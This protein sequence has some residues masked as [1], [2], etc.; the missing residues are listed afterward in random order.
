MNSAPKAFHLSSPAVMQTLLDEAQ[1]ELAQARATIE[2]QESRL[3]VLEGR[4][5]RHPENDDIRQPAKVK[6]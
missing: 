5:Q 1:R 2:H 6:G 4:L 3:R